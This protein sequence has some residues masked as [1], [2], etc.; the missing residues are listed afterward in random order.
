LKKNNIKH[1]IAETPVASGKY[2]GSLMLRLDWATF[3]AIKHFKPDV[4]QFIQF[5]NTLIN[6]FAKKP[7]FFYGVVLP[8][9]Y[10]NIEKDTYERTEN[11]SPLEFSPRIFLENL[12]YRSLMKFL[13][14]EDFY[15]FREGKLISKH[16]KGVDRLRRKKIQNIV[17]VHK[18]V[19]YERFSKIKPN[20]T[21]TILFMGQLS[22]RKGPFDLID[23][24]FQLADKFPKLKLMIA[25]SGS[26]RIASA[27]KKK[28]I[29][30]KYRIKFIGAVSY[31]NKYKIFLK[32]GIF[33]L[34]S[35]ADA[36][37]GVLLEAMACGLP[38]ITTYEAD[39]PIKNGRSG[40]LIHAGDIDSLYKSMEKL[41]LHPTLA[42]KLGTSARK[43][44]RVYSWENQ[45]QKLLRLY[46]MKINR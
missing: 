46:R 39:P 15:N 20:Q 9:I 11:L 19:D 7:I 40:I 41:L 27:L 10:K 23:A 3:W 32:T 28:A 12:F 18:G 4:V 37:P 6:L 17:Y 24:F 42:E 30:L 13:L 8:K 1:Y 31:Q 26:K 25:G 22:Y 44:A 35:Y 29:K 38:V 2:E 43:T 33:C 45:A 16:P 5:T 36:S 14:R 21:Q 34:P